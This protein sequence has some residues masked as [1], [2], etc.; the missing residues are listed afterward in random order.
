ML[1]LACQGL[2]VGPRGPEGLADPRHR[3]RCPVGVGRLGLL[4]LHRRR[5]A[6]VG[7]LGLRL[8]HHHPL[9]GEEA[10]LELH[11]PLLPPVGEEVPLELHH[12]RR[13]LDVA[14]QEGLGRGRQGHQQ[15][16]EAVAVMVAR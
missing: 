2:R 3:R 12:R 6:D 8:P 13:H 9:V 15:Q 1:L 5:R 7:R 14:Q 16:E 10:P 11:H 4:L